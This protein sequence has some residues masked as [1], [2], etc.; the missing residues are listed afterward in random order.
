[1]GTLSTRQ[2]TVAATR[3][4]IGLW[5]IGLR[6]SFFVEA[7]LFRFVADEEDEGLL[8]DHLRAKVN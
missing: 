5:R 6:R 4:R 1:M 7:Q 3:V 8:G 2:K